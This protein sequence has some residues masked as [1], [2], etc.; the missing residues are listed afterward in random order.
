MRI[1]K[2]QTPNKMKMKATIFSITL[3]VALIAMAG[4][5]SAQ[6]YTIN[7]GESTLEW[8]G[9]KVTGQHNGT[10]DISEGDLTYNNQKFSGSFV[11]DMSS[12]TVLDLEPGSKYNTK[13][14]NHLKSEDFFGVKKFPEA[15]FVITNSE[16]MGAGKYTIYGDLTIKGITHPISFPATINYDDNGVTATGTIV[17]DRSKFDVR[18]GSGSFFDNLGDKTIY[19]DMEFTVS[20]KG[21]A[22]NDPGSK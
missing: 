8:V 9:K 2:P 19:D 17:V 21:T 7:T 5:A 15:T 12:I 16:S 22:V 14:T 1:F 3:A 4:I 10:V 13:L 20:L 18:Y 11:I 6:N